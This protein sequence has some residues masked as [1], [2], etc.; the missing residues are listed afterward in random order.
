MTDS[1]NDLGINVKRQEASNRSSRG[2]SQA[3]ATWPDSTPRKASLYWKLTSDLIAIE[4]HMRRRT[5]SQK[6]P[7]HSRR[8]K[9]ESQCRADTI[10]HLLIARPF[11]DGSWVMTMSEQKP[12]F[13][14]RRSVDSGW[15]LLKPEFPPFY[16]LEEI[17][18][19][20]GGRMTDGRMKKPE[21]F[22][23][24]WK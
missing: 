20:V 1:R 9:L 4:E 10:S 3:T 17:R 13:L 15:A 19:G 23:F 22:T 6:I 16:H 12:D 18:N 14:G 11:L 7:I 8:I 21:H 2:N 5:K 24:G